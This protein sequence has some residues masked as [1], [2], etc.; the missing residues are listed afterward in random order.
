M[1]RAGHDPDRLL[2]YPLDKVLLIYHY[3]QVGKSDRLLDTLHTIR[4]ACRAA[5]GGE[6]AA[7]DYNS[8]HRK[9]T[10]VAAAIYGFIR[11]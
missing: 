10:K 7:D 6:G 11:K 9:L 3:I 5:F 2:A 1:S 4:V 8:W